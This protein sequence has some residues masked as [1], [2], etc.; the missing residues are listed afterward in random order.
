MRYESGDEVDPEFGKGIV[1]R[2]ASDAPA[3]V[4]DFAELKI[5]CSR[6]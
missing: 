5:E 6:R 2:K 4:Q 3:Y 1:G